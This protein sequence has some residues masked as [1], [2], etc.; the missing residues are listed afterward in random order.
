MPWTKH[1]VRSNEPQKALDLGWDGKPFKTVGLA[2][3][4][5]GT[6]I[7]DGADSSGLPAMSMMSHANFQGTL[8][9]V[10]DPDDD[11]PFRT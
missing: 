6:G 11:S 1:Y 5:A 2:R 9:E 8:D 7:D 10:D 3:A 4:G